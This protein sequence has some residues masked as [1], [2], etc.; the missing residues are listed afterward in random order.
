[1]MFSRPPKF[2]SIALFCPFALCFTSLVHSQDV[3]TLY[4]DRD[5]TLIEDPTGSFSNG[6]AG[7]VY[8]GRV[9]SNGNETLRRAVF[10]FNLT[11][12]PENVT[13][14][15]S[16]L[17]LHV[18]QPERSGTVPFTLHRITKDWGEGTSSFSGGKGAAAED[19]DATWLHTFYND[20]FWDTPGGDFVETPSATLEFNGTDVYTFE[21]STGIIEDIEYWLEYPSQNY[22]WI[23]I[24]NESGAAFTVKEFSSRESRT[25]EHRPSLTLEYK[26]AELPVELS[27][28]EAVADGNTA[29]LTWQT[30]S[31][32][33]NAGF[34]IQHKE[35]DS[36]TSIAFMRG[37]GTTHLRQDYNFS[38]GNL[39]V[40][41]HKFRLKQ[42]DFDGTFAYSPTVRI[43]I[44]ATDQAF[45]NV[46]PTPFNP[47]TQILYYSQ[48]EEYVQ[49]Q[50]FDVLGKQVAFIHEGNL[51]ADSQHQF[52]FEPS[53]NLPSGLYWVQAIGASNTL[54]RQIMYVK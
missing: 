35:Y 5:N 13:I 34:D 41:V 22:G 43:E 50:V 7:S 2:L 54:V 31:E 17:S 44:H 6:A 45:L 14:L 53:P 49:I 26:D 9:G 23:L 47:S 51:S 8:A 18:S 16:T 29:H 38:V 46:Y 32:L 36:F 37:A 19:L 3:T 21:A 52:T 42:I 28:L 12:L 25:L 24:G 1:M 20:Q 40:G 15:S 33:N 27:F 48:K 10:H 11:T 39:A 4:P 30:L